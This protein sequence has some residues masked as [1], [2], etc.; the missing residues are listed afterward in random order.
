MSEAHDHEVRVPR[1]A[2]IGAAVLIGLTL[3][4]VAFVRL[5]G[6]E[7]AAQVPEPEST[8]ASRALRFEDRPNGDVVVFEAGRD[9]AERRI[10]TLEPGGAGFI[11][12]VLRSL[13]RE[14]RGR[15]IGPEQPFL[16]S[17]QADGQL[18]LED[19][20]TDQRI[21]LQAFGPTNVEAFRSLL[22]EDVDAAEV[23]R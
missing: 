9:G 5:T 3:S 16:L 20:A 7:P 18:F 11:R 22:V 8:V 13:A 10:R 1:A 23:R 19:P 12:G 4:A 14:R 21:Y 15:G 2:L 17:M 6:M